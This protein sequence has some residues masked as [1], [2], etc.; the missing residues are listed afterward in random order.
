MIRRR[1][2]W[3]V[4]SSSFRE[5]EAAA[6]IGDVQRLVRSDG[7]TIRSALQ[8]LYKHHFPVGREA[9]YLL[10]LNLHEQYGAVVHDD[11]RFG[12]LQAFGQDRARQR[13]G[14]EIE[15]RARSWPKA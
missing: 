5:A 10:A 11:R 1:C 14:R 8:L 7:E 2:A 3:K 13:R 12:K 6:V 4:V 15:H 9:A